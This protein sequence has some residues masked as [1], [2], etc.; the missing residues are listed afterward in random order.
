MI[1]DE[2]TRELLEVIQMPNFKELANPVIEPCSLGIQ[3]ERRFYIKFMSEGGIFDKTQSKLF[4][5]WLILGNVPFE[6]LTER[7]FR[8]SVLLFECSFGKRVFKR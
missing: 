7:S 5:R 4:K 6:Q 2:W 3:G 1:T 8:V